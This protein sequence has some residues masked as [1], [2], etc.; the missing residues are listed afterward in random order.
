MTRWGRAGERLTPAECDARDRAA[1]GRRNL[2]RCRRAAD[3]RVAY[4]RW[5]AGLVVPALITM[6]LDLRGMYGPAVD[7]ACLAVE[8]DVDQW[9]AGERYPSW[10]Q[11]RA[12]AQLT[13]FAP[14]W[15]VRDDV[16]PLAVW[17][18]SMVFHMSAA[19]RAYWERQPAP[20]MRYPRHVLEERP[21]APAEPPDAGDVDQLPADELRQ[22]R[23]RIAAAYTPADPPSPRRRRP[24]GPDPARRRDPA[25]PCGAADCPG[26][27]LCAA[28][29]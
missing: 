6:A 10:P 25:A 12:L 9:E 4:A 7:R 24:R 27:L 8:P 26:C 19:E 17:Q 11:L 21:P 28:D 15:F 13:G 14:R 29:R 18:T 20:V 1:A 22:L 2:S 5:R 3:D 23:G 16:E